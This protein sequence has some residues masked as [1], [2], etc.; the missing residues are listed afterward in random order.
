M[1]ISVSN[2]AE[3]DLDFAAVAVGNNGDSVEQLENLPNIQF[4]FANMLP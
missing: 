4:N 3:L 1:F 2:V